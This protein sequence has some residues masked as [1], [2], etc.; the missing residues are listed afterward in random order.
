[1]TMKNKPL[2]LFSALILSIMIISSVGTNYVWASNVNYLN[3]AIIVFEEIQR[4]EGEIVNDKVPLSEIEV[5][6]R[7]AKIAD[8]WQEIDRLEKLNIESYNVDPETESKLYQAEKNL[9]EKYVFTNSENYVGKN[10]PIVDIS[11]N[12]KHKSIVILLD[13]DEIIT[14]DMTVYSIQ[15]LMEENVRE[16]IG[17]N[18]P[19]EVEYGKLTSIACNARTDACR[20]VIG[21]ITVGVQSANSLNTLSYKA[22]KGTD[23]GFVMAGHSAQG[24][25]KIIVQPH[26]DSTK[27]VGT[28][29]AYCNTLNTCDFAFVKA[30]AG[31]SVDPT[32]YKS[33]GLTYTITGKTQDASQSVGTF[34]TKSG[35]GTAVTIGDITEN[36]PNKFYN[37]V[38]IYIGGGDSGSP[39]FTGSSNVNLYGEFY[40]AETSG[41]PQVQIARYYPW[42]YIQ[43]KI[44]AIPP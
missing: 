3:Q 1:M 15:K 23:T 29:T 11:V 22:T 35:A 39:V 6:Q 34:V 44:G 40:A 10:Y 25:N 38:N 13:R 33:S 4:I 24:I 21:G 30:D 32:I 42:D 5:T 19:I 20:P 43:T 36:S 7:Q 26:N 9:L 12:L 31:I 27:R 2:L 17:E 18:L 14:S 41:T 8:L 16:A 37:K 28:V